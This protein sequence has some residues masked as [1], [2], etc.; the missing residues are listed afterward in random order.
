MAQIPVQLGAVSRGTSK[1][2]LADRQFSPAIEGHF[3]NFL[4]VAPTARAIRPA[5]PAGGG[6]VFQMLW[7]PKYGHKQRASFQPDFPRGVQA[8]RGPH[9]SFFPQVDVAEHQRS[10]ACAVRQTFGLGSPRG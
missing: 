5:A 8:E 7:K 6:A 10:R 3:K 9:V 1:Q 2:L 4:Q